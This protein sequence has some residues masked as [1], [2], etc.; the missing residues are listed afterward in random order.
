MYLGEAFAALSKKYKY[1]IFDDL[2]SVSSHKRFKS[3]FYENMYR[4]FSSRPL[5]FLIAQSTD[6]LTELADSFDKIG[7][8][9]FFHTRNDKAVSVT[10]KV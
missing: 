9:Y 2:A 4:D 3:S 1:I 6:D 8:S 7:V 5:V 10:I